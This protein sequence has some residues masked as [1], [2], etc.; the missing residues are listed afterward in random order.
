MGY[1]SAYD[2]A[3]QQEDLTYQQAV[4]M[5][6]MSNH[7]PP[8]SADFA[9]SCI[10]AIKSFVI[11]ALSVDAHGEEE[12]YQQLQNTLIETPIGMRSAAELVEALHLD[13][14]I[15]YELHKHGI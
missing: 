11:A 8:V 9:P 6:L 12:V 5:H 15:D 14:F 7:Y 2:L 1:M 4:E 13:A 10:Q 3:S